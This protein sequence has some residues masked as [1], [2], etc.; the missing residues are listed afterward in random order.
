ME[1]HT[2]S[3]KDK[4][5]FEKY[6]K[7]DLRSSYSF[8]TNYIWCTDSNVKISEFNDC[9]IILWE[10]EGKV[11]MQY[12]QG[13]S[14]NKKAVLQEC[15]DYFDSINVLPNFRFLNEREVLELRE[16]YSNTF[17]FGYDRDNCDYIYE[18]EKLI[19]LSGKKLHSKKN[20]VNSFKKKNNFSYRRM[21]EKDIPECKKLFE[22]WYSSKESNSTFMKSAL[23]ATFKL[24]DS[25]IS[26]GLIGGIIEI[27]GKIIA[28]SIGEK[29]DNSAIIHLEFADRNYQGSYAIINQQFCENEWSDCNF[30][31]REEDMGDEGLRKAKESYQPIKLLESYVAK[32][33]II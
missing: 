14:E 23:S 12:P 25:F 27:D 3:E 5:L 6:V 33:A 17:T 8:I 9:L 11:Y 22:E 26:L 20:H 30:I 31:N 1:F 13:N 19:T 28:C 29:V 10:L 4:T 16:L 24:L 15:C 2:I 32:K 7:N 18:A 21:E